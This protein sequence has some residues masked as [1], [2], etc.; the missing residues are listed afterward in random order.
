MRRVKIARKFDA[1]IAMVLTNAPRFSSAPVSAAR[2]EKSETDAD[3]ATCRL[4]S[5]LFISGKYV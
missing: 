2:C 4:F 5:V 3:G 1:S